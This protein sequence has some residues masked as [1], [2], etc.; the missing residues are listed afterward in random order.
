MSTKDLYIYMHQIAR[1]FEEQ[2]ISWM[3]YICMYMCTCIVKNLEGKIFEDWHEWLPH[4]QWLHKFL[5]VRFQG[6]STIL[7]NRENFTPRKILAIRYVPAWSMNLRYD[8]NKMYVLTWHCT[9]IVHTLLF[10]TAQ[11][12]SRSV[13]DRQVPQFCQGQPWEQRDDESP[14]VW[15]NEEL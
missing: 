6:S 12:P 3:A 1:N 14:M 2:K 13:P 9:Y 4:P 5:R 10:Q 7:E 11:S 15:L 8:M